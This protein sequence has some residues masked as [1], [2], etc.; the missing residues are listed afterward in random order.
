[1]SSY[2]NIKGT[3]KPKKVIKLEK[4]NKSKVADLNSENWITD[5]ITLTHALFLSDSG[6]SMVSSSG[7]AVGI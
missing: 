4:H 6:P 3:K 1:M 2:R 5:D 7:T